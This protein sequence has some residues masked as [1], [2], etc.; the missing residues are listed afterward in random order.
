VDQTTKPAGVPDTPM[1]WTLQVET[2]DDASSTFPAPGT[3]G[4]LQVDWVVQYAYTP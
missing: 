1:R 3:A 2:A 4:H